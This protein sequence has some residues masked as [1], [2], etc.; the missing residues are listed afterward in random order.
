MHNDDTLQH[1][2][3]VMACCWYQHHCLQ[4]TS[5]GPKQ[6]D[7]RTFFRQSA[8]YRSPVSLW[9]LAVQNRVWQSCKPKAHVWL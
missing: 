2:L 7:I 9:Q 4:P 6:N 1:R 8:W 5:S 3:Q